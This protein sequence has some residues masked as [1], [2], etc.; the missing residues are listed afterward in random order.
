MTGT[1]R[2]LVFLGVGAG[3][4]AFKAVALAS[5][6]ARH[7][8]R[9]RTLMSRD[10]CSFIGP[11]SFRAVTGEEV[12]VEPT[13]VDSDGKPAH[14]APAGADAFVLA[15]ATADMI[16]RIAHG[17]AFDAV[18]LGALSAPDLRFFCPAM[19]DSMWE[20]PFVQENVKRLETA[21]WQRIGPVVGRLAEGYEGAG[22]MTEPEEILAVV[23]RALEL[24]R[25]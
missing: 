4:A 12:V 18:S 8:V 2:K 7:G 25:T 10:A 24:P 3:A 22:R 13:A 21:G 15:P 16:G 6:L 23:S 14:L 9:V 17:L 5:L 11:L 19:N 20:N 1:R